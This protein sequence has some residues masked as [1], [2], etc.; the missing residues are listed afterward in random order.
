MSA[1]KT[2][3]YYRDRAAGSWVVQVARTAPD[4]QQIRRCKRV[5][6]SEADAR[7]LRKQLVAELEGEVQQL[8]QERQKEDRRAEAAATLGLD[9]RTLTRPN[10]SEPPPTLRQYLTG[11]WAEHALV[12]QNA[13]TR[14]TTRSHVG[15]LTYFL[16]ERLL[17][18]IDAAA[19]A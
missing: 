2:T 10:G 15:Y 19:V 1:K 13:T 16:G 9:L 8:L 3:G 7:L 17:D 6:G 12:T 11:R 5:R 18:E 4:G 14:R